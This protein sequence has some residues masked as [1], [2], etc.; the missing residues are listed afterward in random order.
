MG[1]EAAHESFERD[2]VKV[3]SDR[4]F[5]VVFCVVFALIALWPLIHGNGIRYWA[6]GIAILVLAAALIRPRLL[7]PLNIIW[8]KIGQLLHRVVNP[9]V[10]GL[11]FFVG[12]L[13]TALVMRARGS[14]PLRLADNK[15][16][17]TTW[18]ERNP[19]GPPPESMR[20][21]F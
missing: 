3:S 13:P 21:L 17:G 9:V 16:R 8:F 19:P 10:M 4:S 14:D 18:V 15:A 11:I 1:K 2:D 7:H 5:G 6:L 20:R 12:V